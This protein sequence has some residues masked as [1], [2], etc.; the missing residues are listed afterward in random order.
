MSETRIPQPPEGALVDQE[1][2]S[3][4]TMLARLSWSFGR[5]GSMARVAQ[6]GPTEK[7]EGGQRS[8]TSRPGNRIP[9]GSNHVP[10]KDNTRK[11]RCT[12]RFRSRTRLLFL[13]IPSCPHARWHKIGGKFSSGSRLPCHGGNF[14]LG[15]QQVSRRAS[16]PSSFSVPRMLSGSLKPQRTR[17][18]R[19]PC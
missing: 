4:G 15:T 12:F 5:R 8:V 7:R 1:A 14:G 6:G 3:K 10:G 17:S 16:P 9:R 2:P 19:L 18:S 13:L 11:G